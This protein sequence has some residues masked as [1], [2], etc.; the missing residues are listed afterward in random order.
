MTGGIF[1]CDVAKGEVMV[2][3]YTRDG[4]QYGDIPLSYEVLM[5]LLTDDSLIGP[6]GFIEIAY[7]DGERAAVRKKDISSVYCENDD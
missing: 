5:G 7:P 3:I 4:A 2:T 1:I 6:E